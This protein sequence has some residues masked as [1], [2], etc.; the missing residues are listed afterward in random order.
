MMDVT[1][2]VIGNR[3]EVSEK[4]GQGG[5]GTVYK[6]QDRQTGQS[7]AIKH[8]KHDA[9]STNRE[10][11][12]RFRR[13][14]ALLRELNHP[15]IVHLIDVVESDQQHYIVMEYVDG[16]SL[17]DVLR[18]HGPL[19]IS[20]VLQI[21]LDLSDALARAHR[22]GV[23]HRD[24][25]PSNVLLAK[26]GTPRLSD[27]GIA[28]ISGSEPIT[29]TGEILGTLAYLP[30]EAFETGEFSE[31]GD[32]WSLGIILYQMLTGQLPFDHTTPVPTLITSILKNPIPDITQLREDVPPALV[33]LLYQMLAKDVKQRLNSVRQ[34]GVVLDALLSGTPITPLNLRNTTQGMIPI[35]GTDSETLRVTPSDRVTTDT[36]Y[37]I[38]GAP[39]QNTHFVGRQADLEALLA[40]FEQENARLI[41]ISGLGGVGKTRLAL[42]LASLVAPR[43]VDGVYFVP[44]GMIEGKAAAIQA[45]ADALNFNF[46][47]NKEQRAELLAF[48]QEKSLLLIL[49]SFEQV[50]E[51]VDLL[52]DILR[53]SPRSRLIV[54]SRERLNL[55]E[56]WVH[57]IEGLAFPQQKMPASAALN[58]SAIQLFVQV[59]RRADPD[60]DPEAHLDAVLDIVRMVEGSPLGIQ[61]AASWLNIMSVE[62]VAREISESLDFLETRLR[63]VP[64]RQR[65]LRAT[66]E[67]SWKTLSDEERTSLIALSIFPATFQRDAAKAVANASLRVL[68]TLVDKSNLSIDKKQGD[69]ALHNMVRTFVRDY[70]DEDEA[71]LA[72]TEERFVRF[73]IEL[74]QKLLSCQTTETWKQIYERT[75]KEFPNLREAW[76][77]AVKRQR[78]EWLD[79]LITPL[80][81]LLSSRNL[82]DEAS[83]LCQAA[84]QKTWPPSVEAKLQAMN[85]WFLLRKNDYEGALR[86]SQK[87]V[88]L[89]S[90]D[91]PAETL[92]FVRSIYAYVLYRGGDYVAAEREAELATQQLQ[93][94]DW[95]LSLALGNVGYVA[96]VRGE[97]EKA[98]LHLKRAYELSIESGNLYGLAYSANNLGEGY[99]LI[100]A[101]DHAEILFKEANAAFAEIGFTPGV[102]FSYANLGD[103]ARLRRD[104]SAQ[105]YQY[106]E[107][108][109]Q[110]YEEQGDK[111]GVADT[112]IQRARFALDG[113]AYE[114]AHFQ[115]EHA[116]V[117]YQRIGQVS[118]MTVALQYLG[119]TAYALDNHAAAEAYF[120]EALRLG[121][122]RQSERQQ[123]DALLGLASLEGEKGATEVAVRWLALIKQHPATEYETR[124]RAERTLDA[125]AERISAEALA[126]AQADLPALEEVVKEFLE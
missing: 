16:G 125:L 8:L 95:G 86:T 53:I 32:I 84:L 118:G 122:E 7:V 74:S 96:L 112:L 11:I 68:T 2:T 62:E 82:V 116:L 93:E 120:T 109:I 17:S 124:Q 65:S 114:E 107:K 23:I 37:P 57:V 18:A 52:S 45:I 78:T 90:D 91:M 25:K 119:E 110:L 43:F 30:P 111:V 121:A 27:F 4:I 81:S 50:I 126:A 73:H 10:V 9:A 21:G 31:R 87:S 39:A 6:G 113:G 99:V 83:T 72:R 33:E 19:P 67:Y 13:E 98:I 24:L 51:A 104:F 29:R 56:E 105:A 5:M 108:A 101:Y 26:D 1:A 14:G 40:L 20:Q 85:A 35:L 60:F 64:E 123:L 34:V 55:Q 58:Y 94:S 66:F 117:I 71:L 61:L 59:A 79:P 89:L 36:L 46:A 92:G 75:T 12:E 38:H 70:L 80:W 41:T 42:Q 103:L 22:L 102:A 47:G 77:I 3:Y 48:L 106:F 44:M 63:N 28:H 49:D 54:T 115:L 76:H 88:R 15:N 69:Y 100:G 97:Y